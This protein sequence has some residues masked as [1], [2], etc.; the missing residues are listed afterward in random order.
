M[1]EVV[2]PDILIIILA[3]FLL[4][5]GIIGCFLPILPGPAIAYAGFFRARWIDPVNSPSDSELV[6]AGVMVAAVTLFDYIVP[7]LGAKKFN[8]S[9]WGTFGCFAGTIIGLFF[10]PLGV[11]LGPF[12]G[13]FCGECIAG[14]KFDLAIRGAFGAFVGYVT[15]LVV[16]CAC[17][18]VLVVWF[19]NSIR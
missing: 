16:K 6:M 9:K 18:I 10:V 11:V 19:M 15:G 2:M 12:I 3:G 17:C 1:P 14:K 13:A 5:T 7:A 8:C 4:G